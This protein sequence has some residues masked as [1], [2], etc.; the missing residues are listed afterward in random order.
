MR[1]GSK[2]FYARD[3]RKSDTRA[4]AQLW[5]Q[6]RNR[7]LENHKFIRQFPIGPYI[8]DF[9]CRERKVVFEI[10][11]ATHGAAAEIARDAART[12]FLVQARVFRAHNAEIYENLNGVLD[13]LLA[14]VE[15]SAA[16]GSSAPVAAPHPNPLPVAK[17]NGER[18]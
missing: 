9:A 6:L 1:E 5:Q 15:A 13:T 8:A 3:L 10:D 14:F 4:E 12:D 11:G 2:T 7:T 16:S 17:G 18:E